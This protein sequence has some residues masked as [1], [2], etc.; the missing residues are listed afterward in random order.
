MTN[1]NQQLDILITRIND[2]PDAVIRAVAMIG[3]S[4]II[5]QDEAEKV[6]LD[7]LPFMQE[8]ACV[9]AE[10]PQARFTVGS[11]GVLTIDPDDQLPR[12]EF[13]SL[14][15]AV[16]AIDDPNQRRRAFAHVLT[17]I[18]SKPGWIAW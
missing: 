18:L 14:I 11:G 2:L 10:V 5:P 6:E 1:F 7:G 4:R 16:A 15:D 9:E 8:L 13:Y 3:L 17:C 12:F